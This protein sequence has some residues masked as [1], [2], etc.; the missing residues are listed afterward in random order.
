MPGCCGNYYAQEEGI[1]ETSRLTGNLSIRLTIGERLVC[2]LW[3]AIP[4]MFSSG[5]F[6]NLEGSAGEER[7]IES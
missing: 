3:N 4:W 6:I 7:L 2:A 1:R 5:V